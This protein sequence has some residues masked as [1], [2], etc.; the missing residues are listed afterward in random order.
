MIKI[1][2]FSLTLLILTIGLSFTV[3]SQT[4]PGSPGCLDPTFGTGGMTVISPPLA[5][6]PKNNNALDMV[7]QSDGKIVVLAR[8]HDTAGSFQAVLV[9]YT[10]NGQLDAT[11]ASGGF[12]YIP[13]EAYPATFA[14][15][16]IKQNI[17]GQEK[18]VVASG[19]KCSGVDCIRVLRYTTGG[20]LDESFG[21]GGVSTLTYPGLFI[22][23]AAVQA[24][25]KLL[26]G[27]PQRPLVRLNANG[28]PDSSFGSN[29]IATFNDSRMLISTMVARPDGTILTCGS[30]I[31]GPSPDFYVARF[32]SNGRSDGSFGSQGKTVIDFAGLDDS[33]SGLT[34]D[35]AGRIIAVGSANI[36]GPM[37]APEGLDAVIV[38]LTSKGSLDRTFGTNGR[39]SFLDIGGGEDSFRTAAI[40][41]DG[42]I[43]ASGKGSLLANST[44]ILVARYNANG[45]LDPT[46][47]GDGWN[48]TDIYGA[49]DKGMAELLQADTA[50]SC[51]KL[52]VA[53]TALT[54]AADV[55]PQYIVGLR[56][57]L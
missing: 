28:S 12:L 56:Y 41:S 9:R 46:F 23:A 33:A 17:G 29:G 7:F 45:T 55:S 18:F 14:R 24:D 43:V 31:G 27:S 49:G 54:G 30:Y 52:V 1:V 38:R 53:G 4:C 48:L 50:C 36:A 15:R 21:T 3:S 16:L 35:T 57:N 5:D 8:A 19:D 47:H 11:F 6:E 42:K 25:Q 22:T 20:T 39:T 34:V 51:T 10:A 40:Q 26:F 44:D 37:S 13:A 2:G 32:T